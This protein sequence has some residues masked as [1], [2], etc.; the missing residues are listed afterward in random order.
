MKFCLTFYSLTIFFI[1]ARKSSRLGTIGFL[2]KFSYEYYLTLWR[3]YMGANSTFV[4]KIYRFSKAYSIN[5]RHLDRV[6]IPVQPLLHQ[7]LLIIFC[8]SCPETLTNRFFLFHK[9]KK[10]IRMACEKRHEK[11]A[12][13]CFYHVRRIVRRKTRATFNIF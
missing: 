9:I 12:G 3:T 10:Q 7:N 5:R 4:L 6:P 11:D 13:N 1:C 8:Q 2:I